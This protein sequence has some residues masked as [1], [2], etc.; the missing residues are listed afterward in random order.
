M[1]MRSRK[2]ARQK[3][4]RAL[5][6]LS[7]ILQT[8]CGGGNKQSTNQPYVEVIKESFSPGERAYF[9]RE[10]EELIRD[11]E[12]LK[13]T[14]S[15]RD[16]IS[17]VELILADIEQLKD[18]VKKD[19]KGW[20]F[21][22]NVLDPIE[23]SARSLVLSR[24]D[25][26]IL[27]GET[28]SLEGDLQ[29][30]WGWV[31]RYGGRTGPREARLLE[32]QS[33]VDQKYEDTAPRVVERLTQELTVAQPQLRNLQNFLDSAE[34][35]L[36]KMQERQRVASEAGIPIPHYYDL[37]EDALLTACESY[38]LAIEHDN[39]NV[40]DNAWAVE[41]SESEIRTLKGS[42]PGVLGAVERLQRYVHEEKRAFGLLDAIEDFCDDGQVKELHGRHKA[43]IKEAKKIVAL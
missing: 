4:I 43:S 25:E 7:L 24:I 38:V 36:N 23:A 14:A 13:G 6:I 16:L 37:D 17:E 2:R 33:I 9:Q 29:L 1:T 21:I 34:G 12:K 39:S 42:D 20:R 41:R 22:R 8:A 26:R 19:K 31:N 5:L 35:F 30:M 18:Q 3:V 32:L 11:L 10:V 27:E 28:P 15:L 40:T